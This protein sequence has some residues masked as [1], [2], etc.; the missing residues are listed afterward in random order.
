MN[1]EQTLSIW[2]RSRVTDKVWKGATDLE[3]K[4]FCVCLLLRKPI[5]RRQKTTA[6]HV[7]SWV[8]QVTKDAAR[9]HIPAR[10]RSSTQAQFQ[11]FPTPFNREKKRLQ[12]PLF[13]LNELGVVNSGGSCQSLW[14]N[15]G[16]TGSQENWV[17]IFQAWLNLLS[18]SS[19]LAKTLLTKFA[20]IRL[21]PSNF[22]KRP[23]ISKNETT[24]WYFVETSEGPRRVTSPHS[25]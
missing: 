14:L 8:W 3:V 1:L 4:H 15:S 20:G 10:F 9:T 6:A 23:T 17:R 19:V 18:T 21:R 11:G 25:W 24:S 22:P 5:N 7:H 13:F 16:L 2:D 12:Y